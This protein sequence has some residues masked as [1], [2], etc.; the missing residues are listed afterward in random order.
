[1]HKKLYN[2]RINIRVRRLKYQI[3]RYFLIR[4]DDINKYADI[5]NNLLK[6]F[7]DNINTTDNYKWEI[8]GKHVSRT[9]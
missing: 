7:E 6:D 4:F 5:I 1:M 9:I 8:I 3:G 2:R